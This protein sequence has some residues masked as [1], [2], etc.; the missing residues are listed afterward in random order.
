LV[1]GAFTYG[2]T[3]VLTDLVGKALKPK[4]AKD[5]VIDGLQDSTDKFDG[6]DP[7][8][9]GLAKANSE[10]LP[11]EFYPTNDGAL[12][13]WTTETLQPGTRIDRYGQRPGR[14]FSPE[15]TLLDARALPVNSNTDVYQVFE[16]VKPFTIQKSIVAPA[17]GKPGFGIQYK[18]PVNSSVLLKRGIIQKLF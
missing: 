13:N 1:I 7:I 2:A 12:G 4:R 18:S 11:A 14:Y 8:E 3:K 5:K 16:V 6:L 9:E 17:F 10:S 15:N